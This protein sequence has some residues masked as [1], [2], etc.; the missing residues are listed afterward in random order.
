VELVRPDL[1]WRE[2]LYSGA[3]PL[4]QW[5]QYEDQCH[6]Y[7]EWNG[8]SAFDERETRYGADGI[9][10][11][12]HVLKGGQKVVHEWDRT[13]AY[14]WVEKITTSEGGVTT[15]VETTYGNRKIVE[16]FDNDGD[17][18][19]YRVQEWRGTDFADQLNDKF[20]NGTTLVRERKWDLSDEKWEYQDKRYHDNGV[21][22]HK[23]INDNDTYTL[24]RVDYEG[25]TWDTIAIKGKII[26]EEEKAY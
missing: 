23:V 6:T 22:Y 8:G 25:K 15:R 4:T 20:Y 3:T 17:E 16:I 24:D 2:T 7:R 19:T 21:V 10:Y 9:H 5:D 18:W 13:D 26:N 12:Q 14:D 1:A 11:Y